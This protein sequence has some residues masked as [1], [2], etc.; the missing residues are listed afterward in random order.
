MEFLTFALGALIG[1]ILGAALALL[2]LRRSRSAGPDPQEV[3]GLR[4]RLAAS[5][6]EVRLLTSQRDSEDAAEAE[7]DAERESL[8]EMLIPVRQS[9]ATMQQQMQSMERDRVAQHSALAEQL[10]TA[11]KSDQLIIEST[12][13]LMGSLHSTSARGHWGEVQLRRVVEA[14]GML[15]H[16]DFVE[17]HTGTD[18]DGA[19]LRP[20]LVVHLPGER[21]L[22]LDAKAPL[23]PDDAVAQAKALRSRVEELARKR[24]WEAVDLSPEVVLCF[25]PAESLLSSALE[26]DPGL[27]DHAMTRGVSLVSPASLLAALKAVA[28]AW[29]HERMA[30]N[31]GAVVEASRVLHQRLS[32]LGGHLDQLGRALGRSVEQYNKLVG[33]LERSV[34]PQVERMRTL[35]VRAASD[36]AEDESPDDDTAEAPPSRLI[37]A[38]VRGLT[39]EELSVRSSD[40]TPTPAE[41]SKPW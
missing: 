38:E 7:R 21:Q 1:L 4:E 27:L 13:A 28:A 2:A 3:A 6:A 14:A 16:V 30:Q 12:R 18:V 9:L 31:A 34:F 32:T 40:R 39:R 35:E 26:A 15:P 20:D 37:D 41:S 25:V 29:R 10:S 22:V 17:Q 24:Y 5:E 19:T 36:E 23:A 11:A 33:S 8:I